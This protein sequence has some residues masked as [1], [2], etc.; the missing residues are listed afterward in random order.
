LKSKAS[1]YSVLINTTR[2]IQELEKRAKWLDDVVRKVSPATL[3]NPDSI[4][5][6]QDFDSGHPDPG[7]PYAQSPGHIQAT[8]GSIAANTV[9][10]PSAPSPAGS[11][12]TQI[13]PNQP[14]RMTWNSYH[15]PTP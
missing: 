14:W 13:G 1:S 2:H 3:A 4:G 12:S 5:G 6:S 15:W 10:S 8:Q 7:N 9:T 11:T